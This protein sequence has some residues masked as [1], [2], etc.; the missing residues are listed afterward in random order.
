MA[1]SKLTEP[2]GTDRID[3]RNGLRTQKPVLFQLSHCQ[4]THLFAKG[5][6]RHLFSRPRSAY[7]SDQA[8][9]NRGEAATQEVLSSG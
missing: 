7:I 5:G 8:A 2:V 6:H 4:S 3:P 9:C 1:F